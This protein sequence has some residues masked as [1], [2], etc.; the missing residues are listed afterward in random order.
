VLEFAARISVLCFAASY[1]VA[2]ANEVARVLW[3]RLAAWPT[4]AAA[5]AGLFAQS[6]FL[7]SRGFS[8]NRLPISTPFES[9]IVLS[10]LTAAVY[11]F[12]ALKLRRLTLGLFLLPVSLA[13]SLYA[14]AAF[15]RDSAA[16]LSGRFLGMAHGILLLIAVLFVALAIAVSAMYLVKSRQLRSAAFLDRLR[17]P[18]LERLDHWNYLSMTLGWAFLTLGVAIG[19][20]L[21][22]L[23]L[24]DPKVVATFAAWLALTYL[25]NYRRIHPEH[26]GKRL[27][28]GMI[29]A[30]A[31]LIVAVVGDPIL[32]TAHQTARGGGP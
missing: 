17:L 15:D 20:G 19:F 24:T 2:V 7:V 3:P 23:A 5:A 1:G 29:V 9:L 6:M 27:A 22:K 30:G 31:I 12:V 13:L 4:L 14:A 28:W 26:R 10:W 25:A 8:Q 32:G 11:L 16:A 18:S 21:R